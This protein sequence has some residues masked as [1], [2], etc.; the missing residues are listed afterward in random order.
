[1]EPKRRALRIA[2]CAT[3]A[4]IGFAISLFA[5]ANSIGQA[6]GN[7]PTDEG[8]TYTFKHYRCFGDGSQFERCGWLGTV[9]NNGIVEQDGVE[10]RDAVPPKVSPGYEI[11]A[12]WSYRDPLNAWNIEGSRAW[13][14][15][16][17]SA[18]T[19]FAFMALMLL[20]A[21]YWWRRYAREKSDEQESMRKKD[22]RKQRPDRELAESES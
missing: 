2:I 1:M 22:A 7:G 21:I 9:S 20:I 13:L 4:A 16:V 14:N 3:V 5:M 19:S 8:V 6:I 10:Y 15:T 18:A 11:Q 12:L 17:A